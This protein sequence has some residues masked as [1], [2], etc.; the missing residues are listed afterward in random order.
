MNHRTHYRSTHLQFG[1]HLKLQSGKNHT[2]KTCL[3]HLQFITILDI[4]KCTLAI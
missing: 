2:Q 4:Q 1:V 3:L